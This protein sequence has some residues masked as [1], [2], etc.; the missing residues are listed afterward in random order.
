[1]I[2]SS[3]SYRVFPAF[4]LLF[5]CNIY[6]VQ[7]FH[8]HR[9]LRQNV[10]RSKSITTT[11]TYATSATSTDQ[12]FLN[13]AVACAKLGL[14]HTFPNPAVGCVLVNEHKQIIGNGFHPRAGYPHAEVFALLQASG[15]VSDGVRAAECVLEHFSSSPDSAGNT[16]FTR[17]Q[18]LTTQYRND[19]SSLFQPLSNHVSVTAYVTLEPCCHYGQ[20]PPCALAL[21]LAGVQRVVVGFRDPNPRVDG[22]GV[23]FLQQQGITVDLMNDPACASLVTAFCQRITPRPTVWPSD[24]YNQQVTGAMRSALRSVAGR[25]KAAGTLPEVSWAKDMLVDTQLWSLQQQQVEDDMDKLNVMYK[26][27]KIKPE[28][29]E[30]LDQLLWDH[31][32]VQVRLNNAVNKKKDA[33][34]VGQVIAAQL[35]AHVTQTVG[36]TCLLY[37]PCVPPVLNLEALVQEGSSSSSSCE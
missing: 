18:E 4:L 16:E 1:M 31:E 25:Q 29:M 22:G 9:S 36:H 8:A 2:H 34:L 28:W 30:H 10:H 7:S 21:Q 11:H 14:G 15:H 3:L 6:S 24:T 23:Q 5:L 17:I 19:P 37:R 27:I 32:L 20:T 35:Q 12:T 26:A 33:K 13:Q